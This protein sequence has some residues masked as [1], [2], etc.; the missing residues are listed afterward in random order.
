MTGGPSRAVRRLTGTIAVVLGA[1]LV[2]TA[3]VDGDSLPAAKAPLRGLVWL[4]RPPAAESGLPVGGVALSVRWAD[5][6]PAPGADATI[7]VEGALG[8]LG[9]RVRV[10]LRVLAGVH[11]PEWVKRLGGAPVPLREPQAREQGVVPRFWTAEVGAAYDELQRALAAR[12]DGDGRIVEVAIS[13][14]TT[15]N[16]EPAL[17]QVSTRENVT[18]LLRAGYSAKADLRCQEE[19]IEAHRVWR[20]TRSGLAMNP[21]Q[22]IDPDGTTATDVGVSIRLMR[23][24]RET[25]GQRCVLENNSI[26]W[27]P[28]DASYGAVYEAMRALGPPVLFQTAGPRRVGDWVRAVRWAAEQG[29]Q[30]VEVEPGQVESNR[31]RAAELHEA[32]LANV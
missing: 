16:A 11:A 21:Y 19:A 9:R 1:G 29:A 2:S 8:S 17:R 24:C 5:L 4:N 25:L 32:L 6:A 23:R 12:F 10:K 28:L 30:A 27:P 20:R 18:A 7:A 15:F 22:R 26:R 31:A 3:V 14:C 13:R